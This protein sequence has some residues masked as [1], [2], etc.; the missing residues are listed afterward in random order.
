M[1][2]VDTRIGE[3]AFDLGVPTPETVTKLYDAMDFQ[4]AVLCY[5][6]AAPIVGM[7]SV[8]VALADNAGAGSGDPVFIAGYRDVSTMLG[9]NV[10]TPYVLAWVD[11]AEGPIVLH[12]PAGAT[13]GALIDWWDRPIA[14]T[15]AAGIDRG[16]GAVIVLLG[17]GQEVPSDLPVSAHLLR[18]RTNSALLFCRVLESDRVQ[19]ERVASALR[20][21]RHGKVSAAT[22]LLR[23]RREGALTSM[24][25][26]RGLAYWECLAA[27]LQHAPIEDRDRFFAAMLKP[28]G[29]EPGRPFCPDARQA[30]LLAEAAFVGEATA[31][32]A[33][34]FKRFP[35][36]RFRP[37]AHWEFFI[38]PEYVAQQ[39][40][41]DG[42]RFEERTTF[43][44]EV[45][46]ASNSVMTKTPG[47]GSAYLSVYHDKA[48]RAFDGA[49]AYRLRMPPD[50]PAKLFWSVTLYDIETRCLIQNAQQ[51][52][53]RSSRHDLRRNADGSVDL[54]F[55]PGAPKGFETNWIPTMPG[56]AWYAY[57]RLF[58]PLEAYFD[59]SWPL[60][61]VEQA[62]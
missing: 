14:D 6:W 31:K 7:Q 48:G 24:A 32:A 27:A 19:I 25:H 53:D 22:R 55:A 9:S 17:P 8:K 26:P 38:P 45:M 37:D 18:S 10:T 30:A 5:L 56:K 54:V 4:R 2:M 16:L 11:L 36:I 13:G 59:R 47:V 57:L 50:P 33:S 12:Y 21:H 60:P 1:A 61:D 43:F 15:G 49:K 41:A 23:F 58:G 40:T 34:W 62:K 3:L 20:I 29:I 35:D 42:T 39:D 44:Y 28:L 52:A 46:G 51:I